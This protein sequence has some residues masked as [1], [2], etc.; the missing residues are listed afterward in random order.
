MSKLDALRLYDQAVQQLDQLEA[1]VKSTPQRQRLN[2]LHGFL[3]EQQNQIRNTQQQIERR[4]EIIDRLSTQFEGLQHQYELELGEFEI[5]EKDEE[6]TAAEMSEARSNMEALLEKVSAARKELFDTLNW[7]EKAMEDYKLTYNKA[8]K[9]KKE[10][11]EVRAQ[12]EADLEAAKPRIAELKAAAENLKGTVEPELLS[13]Y[14]RIKTH[15]AAPMAKVENNQCSGCYMSLPTAVVK[16]VAAGLR[17]IECEN[18][19]RIL[20]TT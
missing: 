9:A 12:C 16:N 15:H 14:E 5:M 13:R 20:Y 8:A 19:G 2:K 4:Q 7:L 6:C 1:Q 3:T 17:I 10:Y 18:C 11:D